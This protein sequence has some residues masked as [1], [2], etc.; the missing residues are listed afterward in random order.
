MKPHGTPTAVRLDPHAEPLLLRGFDQVTAALVELSGATP[1]HVVC[2]APSSCSARVAAAPVNA[3]VTAWSGNR[4]VG[5]A[6]RGGEAAA[7][8]ARCAEP[9]PEKGTYTPVTL[10]LERPEQLFLL[11]RGGELAARVRTAQQAYETLGNI[12]AGF[13][14]PPAP[15]PG[16]ATLLCGAVVHEEDARVLLFPRHWMTHLVTHS[17]RLGRAG[18]HVRPD[19]FTHLGPGFLLA[20]SVPVSGV[21]TDRTE[22]LGPGLDARGR[23]LART[24]NWAAR[25]TTPEAVHHLTRLLDALPFHIGTQDEALAFLATP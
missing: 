10:T 16:T 1:G 3:L 17:S 2:E 8:A 5:I 20:G 14:A 9:A 22:D 18:W 23:L 4:A 21:L 13:A 12:V 6:A 15:V 19:P 11:Y 24:V 7:V 25:P